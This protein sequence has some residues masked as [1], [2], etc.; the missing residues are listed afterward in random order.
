MVFAVSPWFET[1]RRA[2][3]LVWPEIHAC[4]PG[5]AQHK[6]LRCRPGIVTTRALA[7][8]VLRRMTALRL[9]CTAPGTLGCIFRRPRRGRL[10]GWPH[11]STA[12]VTLFNP[13]WILNV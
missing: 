10:E 11:A 3:L 1:R 2:A 9:C 13:P 6:V 5:A 12:V 8:P 7:V 4:F